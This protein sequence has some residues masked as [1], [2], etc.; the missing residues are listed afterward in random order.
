MSER[1]G[2]AASQA[3]TRNLTPREAAD[4]SRL[5]AALE[6]AGH[7]KHGYTQGLSAIEDEHMAR[8]KVKPK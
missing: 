2:E 3:A 1:L 6:K 4:V 8:G 5:S 7:G